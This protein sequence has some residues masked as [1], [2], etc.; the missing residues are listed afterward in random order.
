LTDKPKC[1]I[2]AGPTASGKTWLSVKLALALDGEVI[3]ADSMQV[4]RAMDIG[5]AKP[6]I[7]EQRGVPHLLMDVVDPDEEFNAAIYR[8]LALP[9][10]TD[11][12]SRKKA[13][14][15]TGGTGLYIKSLTK[16]LFNCPAADPEFRESMYRLCEATGSESLHQQLRLI[17]PESA[18]R[19]HPNDRF[20]IIRALEINHLTSGTRSK[21]IREHGF[22]DIRLNPLKICLEVERDILYKRINERSISMVDSGLA[23]ETER[24]LSKGFSPDLKSMQSI[25]YRHMIRF[26]LGAWGIEETIYNIQRDTRRYAKRQLTWFKADHEYIWLRPD[27]FNVILERVKEFLMEQ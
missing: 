20:R 5:T 9:L 22:S 26:L 7:E 27:N 11:I 8:S 3:N 25:G 13:C 15:I 6:T 17:D 14:L 18:E 24:L 2:I 19:I 21:L 16:G 23:D 10:V 1:I 12:V 4:Y